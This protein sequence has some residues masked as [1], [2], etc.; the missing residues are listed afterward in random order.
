MKILM[1]SDHYPLSPRVKKIRNSILKLYPE[2]DIKVFAWNRE[3]TTK[4]EDYVETFNQDL[5]YGNKLSKLFNLFKFKKNAIIFFDEF[6]PDYV[7]AIDLEMCIVARGIS[8]KV[9][10][11]YEVYDIK[12]FGNKILNCIREKLELTIIKNY[13]SG[14]ILAS[15]YFKIYY[16]GKGASKI[17][18]IIIN[19][20][21]SN[22]IK[23]N[24]SEGFMS[25]YMDLLRDKI[26]IGFIGTIRYKDILLN[27]INSVKD[28]DKVKI[29]L[30]GSGPHLN[31]IKEYVEKNNL[32]DKVIMTGRYK[33]ADLEEIYDACDYI[34]A[35]YPNK[36]LNVKY[37]ISNKFFE[38]IVFNKKVIVSENTMLGDSVLAL[39]KGYVVNPY[40]PKDIEALIEKLEINK[41]KLE[42]WSFGKGFF[43]EDEE[44]ELKKIYKL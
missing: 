39:K 22:S 30:S 5:G 13:I 27:L 6:K 34:W 17:D 21:P 3:N 35:A 24:K 10:L 20:K 42:K 40:A 11:I 16:N 37:A 43:W 2:S 28:N 8:K 41:H 15:P 36:D 1:L 25:N 32:Q 19:N 18:K 31:F 9:R 38:S 23:S 4:A 7:H 44:L 14:M 12:F 33:E 29:L 26:V